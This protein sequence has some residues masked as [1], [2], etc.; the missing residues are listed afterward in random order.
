MNESTS[1]TTLEPNDLA[2]GLE[3]YSIRVNP[4]VLVQSNHISKWSDAVPGAYRD[5]VTNKQFADSRRNPVPLRIAPLSFNKQ[6]VLFPEGDL[7]SKPLCKSVNGLVPLTIEQGKNFGLNL[8]PQALRCDNCLM[9]GARRWKEY[10]NPSSKLF[11]KPPSCKERLQLTFIDV[12]SELPY[13]V[14]FPAQST[15]FVNNFVSSVN[16]E[17]KSK[18]NKESLLP[19]DFVVELSSSKMVSAK[20]TFFVAQFNNLEKVDKIGKYHHL[21]N[22]FTQKGNGKSKVDDAIDGELITA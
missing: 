15:K 3:T 17:V 5:T 13:I 22:E 9:G 12:E 7:N 8:E 4:V 14:T 1:L 16:R 10:H 18:A 21:F 2:T 11:G 20:G 19:C 6:R